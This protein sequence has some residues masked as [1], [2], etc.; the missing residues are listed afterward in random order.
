MKRFLSIT[1]ITITFC[2]STF[3]QNTGIGTANPQ[4]KLDV[5]GTF[6]LQQGVAVEEISKD[7]TF[8][9]ASDEILP[10]QLAVKKY[11]QHGKWVPGYQLSDSTLIL[12]DSI[13]NQQTLIWVDVQGNYAYAIRAGSGL[14]IYDITNPDSIQLRGS[15]TTN[16]NSPQ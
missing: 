16:M 3:A 15:T 4:A 12:R 6:R 13:A 10:T 1:I 2:V 11:L 5:N 8:L 9:Q 14:F 7:T